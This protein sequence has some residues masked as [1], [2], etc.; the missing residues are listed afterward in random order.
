MNKR[1]CPNRSVSRP[2]SGIEIAVETPNEV[3]IQVPCVE[4][5]PMLP[6][7]VGTETLAIVVSSTCMKV[8]SET[9]IVAMMSAIPCRGTMGSFSFTMR[10][11]LSWQPCVAESLG[12][13][14]RAAWPRS[15]R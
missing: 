5:I 2:V 4:L 1:T 8:D 7:M 13:Q 15:L 14:W 11:Q 6:A 10:G 9:P 12:Q 3:M